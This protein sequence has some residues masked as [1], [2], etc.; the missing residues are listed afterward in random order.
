MPNV[1]GDRDKRR[2]GLA[3]WAQQRDRKPKLLSDDTNR[4]HK[5]S[6]IGDDGRVIELTSEGVPHQMDA[7]I[8]V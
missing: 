3:R 7:E 6:V 4:L 8:H 1:A 2:G 5:I